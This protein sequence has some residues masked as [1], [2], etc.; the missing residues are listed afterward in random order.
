MASYEVV[1]QSRKEQGTGASRRLRLSGRVPA[2]VYGGK[3]DAESVDL[4]HNAIWNQLRHEKFQSN[5]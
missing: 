4:D 1:A 2:I 3:M 5:G